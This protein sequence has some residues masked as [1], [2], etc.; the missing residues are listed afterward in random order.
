LKVYFKFFKSLLNSLDSIEFL[1]KPILL[2]VQ[3]AAKA[4]LNAPEMADVVE[5]MSECL[6]LLVTEFQVL[7]VLKALD[8]DAFMDFC[9]KLLQ[10]RFHASG[11]ETPAT[12]AGVLVAVLRY[13]F[14]F[15]RAEFGEIEGVG[16]HEAFLAIGDPLVVFS[17]LKLG[18]IMA[19]LEAPMRE[20]LFRCT[21]IP[22][23]GD[24]D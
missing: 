23:P 21:V 8:P 3:F 6:L 16:W 11:T 5:D 15:F 4:V 2:H 13:E 17:D 12:L 9:L 14:D 1:I 19:V 22:M 7:P 20:F 18:E 10:H 24:F